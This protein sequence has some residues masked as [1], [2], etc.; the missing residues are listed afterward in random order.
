MLTFFRQTVSARMLLPEGAPELREIEIRTHPITGRTCRITFSRS[1]EREPG[2]ESLPAPPPFALDRVS[3]PFCR[4]HLET[5]TPRLIPEL[6][7]EGR[8]VRGNS[9]L[10]P[11]LFPYGR[12]SAA[13]LF[14]DHHSVEIGKASFSCYGDSFLNCRDYLLRI[15]AVDPA[16]VFMAI[17]QNHLPSAGGSLLHPH[18]QVQADHLPANRQRFLVQRAADHRRQTGTRLFSEY[19]QTEKVSGE[20]YIGKTGHWEW[21][22][23]FA[24]EGFFEIWGILPGIT[25]LKQGTEAHWRALASGI[26]CTQKFYRSLGRNGYNFGLLLLEDGT[27]NLEWCAVLTVRSNYAAWVRSDF[28]GF[29]VML[30]DMATFTAPEQTAQMARR[31]WRR[32]GSEDPF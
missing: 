20:R 10:F 1:D 21:L 24:P 2:A 18:L 32:S 17:T 11:N 31:F 12:Y 27:D 7:P 15:L 29:E 23:A 19:L 8:M 16:A 6:C 5:R 26:L 13:S 28:T 25:S 3:G 4:S 14:D 9:I 22:A 30:G